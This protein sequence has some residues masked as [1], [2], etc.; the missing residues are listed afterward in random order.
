MEKLKYQQRKGVLEAL[1][2]QQTP[3]VIVKCSL[4]DEYLTL[5]S[6]LKNAHKILIFADTLSVFSKERVNEL[7]AEL[8]NEDLFN[9]IISSFQ[10][11]LKT[12]L[13]VEENSIEVIVQSQESNIIATYLHPSM[14]ESIVGAANVRFVRLN[15]NVSILNR[16]GELVYA[17]DSRCEIG[18]A[19]SADEER[20]IIYRIDSLLSKTAN[21]FE[22]LKM[23]SSGIPD[24]EIA[25]KRD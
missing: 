11:A 20:M 10:E 17:P 21:I 6:M 1:Y 22:K 3:D 14:S 23:L 13:S 2:Q 5:I 15:S 4:M 19:L 25:L 7:S 18:E 16:L 24:S 12:F 8:Q 9:E